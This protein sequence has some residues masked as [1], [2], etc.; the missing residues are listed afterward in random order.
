[1]LNSTEIKNVHSI[2]KNLLKNNFVYRDIIHFICAFSD[3][4]FFIS[5]L[6]TVLFVVSFGYLKYVPVPVLC[7]VYNVYWSLRG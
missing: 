4:F 7:I 5:V 1:M 2:A 3:V 6:F